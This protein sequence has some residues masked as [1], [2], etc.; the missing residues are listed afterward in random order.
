MENPGNRWSRLRA[1]WCCAG[2]LLTVASGPYAAPVWVVDGSATTLSGSEQLVSPMNGGAPCPEEREGC[3]A[4]VDLAPDLHAT[5]EAWTSFRVAP[6]G[7]DLW[8]T[9]TGVTSDSPRELIRFL[10][11]RGVNGI[12]LAD[13]QFVFSLG[14]PQMELASAGLVSADSRTSTTTIA[15]VNVTSN[16]LEAKAEDAASRGIPEGSSVRLREMIESLTGNH[17]AHVQTPGKADAAIPAY[18]ADTARGS[19]DPAQGGHPQ[20]TRE[21]RSQDPNDWT[22]NAVKSFTEMLVSFVRAVRDIFNS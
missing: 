4:P 8:P 14:A 13:P 11:G 1:G 6:S 20:N 7:A 12:R 3:S 19:A 5:P 17:T 9:R 18:L 15:P 16:T 21:T 22:V 10:L 2:L